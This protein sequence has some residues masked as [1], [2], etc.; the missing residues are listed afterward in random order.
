MAAQVAAVAF[1]AL[2]CA[3]MMGAGLILALLWRAAH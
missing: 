2:A 3:A 1:G